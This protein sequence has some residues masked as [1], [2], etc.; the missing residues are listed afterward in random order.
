MKTPLHAMEIFLQPG[1]LWFGDDE[2]RIRTI[3]G[4]C[5]AV[6]LWHPQRHVGGMCHYMLPMRPQIQ[7]AAFR[8]PDGRYGDEAIELL[9][10]EIGAAGTRP[11]E[12]IV[13]LFGGGRMFPT[14]DP[15]QSVP[16]KNVAAARALVV[17]HGL[18]VVAEHLGGQ[19]HRHVMLDIWSGRTWLRHS[20][21]LPMGE[22]TL[23]AARA[24]AA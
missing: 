1:E 12:Y 10:Q 4:S 16:N 22:A 5:V 18:K 7:R 19:G 6:T 15:T 17:R 9:I 21:L 2:T 24:L 20:S 8:A 14:A 23:P 13:K 3:L 11:H